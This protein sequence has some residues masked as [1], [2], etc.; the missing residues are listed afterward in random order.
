MFCCL[1]DFSIKLIIYFA[2]ILGL[3]ELFVKYL[4]KKSVFFPSKQIEYSPVDLKIPF[5]DIYI[6]TKDDIIL[7]GWFIPQREAKFTILFCHGNAGN[8]GNRL[9]KID[10]LHNIGLNILIIDYRGYGLSTG[11]PF[12]AGLYRDAETAYEY[13]VKKRGI[14]PELILLYGESLGGVAVIELAARKKVA[15]LVIEGAFTNGRDMAKRVFP[16]LPS[17]M[18]GRRL[19]SLSRIQKITSPKLFIHSNIDEVVPF[20]LAKKLYDTAVFPKKLIE[21]TGSHNEGFL[22][23]RDLYVDS[24]VLFVKEL[25][26]LERR[27]K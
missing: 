4:E 24:I 6:T 9:E 19:D 23:S 15:G 1:R 17:F 16:Y 5:E 14:K 26:L 25:A 3:L 11:K 2:V 8:I 21:I 18:F 20:K 13:L 27:G 10:L 7:N 22:E 12:E